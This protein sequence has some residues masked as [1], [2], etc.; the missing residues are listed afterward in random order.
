MEGQ[1]EEG[2]Q[3]SLLCRTPNPVEVLHNISRG[4]ESHAL[5]IDA[6]KAPAGAFI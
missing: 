3:S 1:T 2:C 6:M 5:R 4:F